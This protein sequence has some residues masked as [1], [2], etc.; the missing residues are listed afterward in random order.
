MCPQL[1][2][3]HLKT[4]ALKLQFADGLSLLTRLQDL[5]HVRIQTGYYYW[6]GEEYFSWL[7]PTALPTTW[8][9]LTYPLVHRRARKNLRRRYQGLPPPEIANAESKLVE[10]GR[11]LGIELTKVGHG[12]DLLDWMDD[13]YGISASASHRKERLTT[14]PKLQSFWVEFLDRRGDSEWR[15]LE[16]FVAGIRPSVDFQMRTFSKDVFYSSTLQYY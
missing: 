4:W 9:G 14:L 10:R 12:D 7:N 2:E 11:E 6:P 13:H 3:L 8:G 15:K 16:A 1:Q 5:E